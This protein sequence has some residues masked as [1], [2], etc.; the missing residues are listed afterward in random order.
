MQEVR[1]D[2]RVVGTFSKLQIGEYGWN[3]EQRR[4]ERDGVS[5]SLER[6]TRF[7]S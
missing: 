5:K 1:Y 6:Q 3:K 4:Y 2:Y 7:K